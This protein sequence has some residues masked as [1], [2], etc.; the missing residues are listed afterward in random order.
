VIDLRHLSSRV[1]AAL[2]D[3]GRAT[4]SRHV[5]VEYWVHLDADGTETQDALISVGAVGRGP[6]DVVTERATT[7][8]EVFRRLR[9]SLRRLDAPA[10]PT[11]LEG[12]LR[13]AVPEIPA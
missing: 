10:A 13:V 11:L 8:D 5:A 1:Q 7:E 9:E 4:W 3:A 6:N 2:T 12:D